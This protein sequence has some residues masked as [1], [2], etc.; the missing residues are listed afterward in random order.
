MSCPSPRLK[1]K[2]V[3]LLSDHYYR[4]NG[5]LATSTVDLLVSPDTNIVKQAKAMFAVSQSADVPYRFA[6]TNSFYNGGSPNVSDSYGSALWVI[7]H[8]FACA[9]NGAQGI[10]LHGGG[11][12]TG[13]TPIA[14]SNGVVVEARPE[15]YG[16][17]L[18]TLAGQGLLLQTA[19]SAGGLDATAYATQAVSGAL[20]IIINN[21]DQTQTLNAVI[22]L[23]Q[24]VTSAQLIQM[25]GPSLSATTGI[26]IQGAAIQA[27]GDFQPGAA[28]ALQ[29]SGGSV[30]CY[31]SPMSAV[32]VQI[33]AP[34]TP[35]L[36][37]VSSRRL[38]REWRAGVTRH[39]IR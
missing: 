30:Q 6:E 37:I 23:P 12:S 15:F 9:L 39:S 4:A 17:T 19:I 3:I 38:P 24:T 34:L 8:L 32:L 21:K 31:V 18:F 33:G 27:N 28:T 25:T 2:S 36:T 5:Q 11:N 35:P 26:A 20:S 7:D 10:N 29:V 14:D 22:Q 13:Y 1:V 16:V